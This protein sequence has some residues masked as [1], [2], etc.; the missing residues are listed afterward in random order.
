MLIIYSKDTSNRLTYSLNVFF[1][2]S[3]GLEFKLVN[4]E[5]YFINYIGPKINYSESTVENAF[6]IL[7]SGILFEKNIKLI[8]PAV[9]NWEELPV[10]FTSEGLSDLP[11]D[12]LAMTFFLASR[13]EEYTPRNTD[14]HGRFDCKESH[15]YRN[16]YLHLPIIDLIAEKIRCLLEEKF[17]SLE[18]RTSQYH[19]IPTVDIDMAYAHLGKGIL[20]SI[21]GYLKLLAKVNFSQVKERIQVNMGMKEDPF[22]NFQFIMD[23][24]EENKIKPVFFAHLGN[25][26]RYDKNISWKN[27]K[28]RDL[29]LWI[30]QRAEIGIHPSYQTFNKPEFIRGEKLRLE[31]IIRKEVTKS[32]QHF[33]RF[34][35]PETF[36]YLLQAGITDDF[37][38]GYAS[39]AGFRGGM[40]K[41]WFFY[42]LKA[43]LETK[44]KLHPFVFMDTSLG[45]YLK[46]SPSEYSTFVYKFI[47]E[48]KKLNGELIGI[49]HNYDLSDNS[50]KH[51]A[52]KEIIKESK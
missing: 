39:D 27:R 16:N 26:G 31:D 41:P 7:P 14:I 18:F 38:M 15:A 11:F 46:L 52:F 40:C 43:E 29:L 4:D 9:C 1:R 35:L 10:F 19:F 22:D 5:D 20:R 32:R 8:D 48:T 17:P 42:D 45:D 24:F 28:L 12:P 33:V 3:M 36:N 13:Y 21:A 34:K 44:L 37:S 50:F 2:D 23:T 6:T 49:W 30:S 51:K 25:Y 47:N